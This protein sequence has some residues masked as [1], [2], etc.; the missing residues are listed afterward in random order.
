M[1]HEYIQELRDLRYAEEFSSNKE[2]FDWLF[3]IW[4]IKVIVW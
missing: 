2:N 1:N 4:L 3:N